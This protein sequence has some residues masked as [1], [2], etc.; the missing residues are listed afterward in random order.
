MTKNRTIIV[1]FFTLFLFACDY[2][3]QLPNNA[4]EHAVQGSYAAA[5]SEDASIAITS[6]INHGLSVWDLNS[7]ALKYQWAH[8][9]DQENLVLA[10]DIA[11]DNSVAVTA[12][13]QTFALWDLATGSN[14]GFWKIKTSSIRDIAI[15][16]NGK[17][18][19]YGRGDGVVVHINLQTGRRIEFLGHQ[20]KI[21][22]VDLSPN[23]LYALTGSNDYTAFLWNTN[24]AQVIYRMNHG[25]RVTQVA[26]DTQGRKAFT[27]DSKKQ[28]RVWD[29]RTGDVVTQLKYTSRQK[30]FSSARFN[31]DATLLVTGSPSRKL[32]LWDALTGKSLQ[33]WQV[34]PRKN[35]RPKSAVVYDAAFTTDGQHLVSESSNGLSERWQI[36]RN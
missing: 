10:I 19:V 24:S 16:N 3:E 29:L 15:S 5:V 2:Q 21:N 8:Q 28:A 17:Y 26:L 9:G 13:K 11:N 32:A 1:L 7:N 30:I 27:A 25:S 31:H 4:Q 12:D 34:S 18:V 20:E 14:Q 6:S 23:G 22:A 33:Q 36:K 35:S